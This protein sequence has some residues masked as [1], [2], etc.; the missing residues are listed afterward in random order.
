MNVLIACEESQ[1]VCIE[2]RKRGH[3]AYSCDIQDCSGC[4]PEWH[5]K[6]DCIP[7]LNGNC[8][9][10]TMDGVTHYTVGKW[11]L[12]IAHPPCTFL[13]KAGARWMYANGE[14]NTDRYA[15]MLNAKMF[16]Q[17]ISNADC[18]RI[19]I[20][21][22]VPLKLACLPK[23]SQI[24]QP[25]LFDEFGE[26]PF[27]KTTCLWFYGD[28]KPLIATTP[29]KLP[30]ACYCPS[31]TSLYSKGLA[32]GDVGIANSSKERSKTFRGIAAAMAEQWG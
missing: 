26:H 11:D 22:P 10:V 13:S 1:R 30:I 17:Q 18:D 2:F 23:P 24:I 25:Y 31:N 15:L 4:H 19:V 12:I 21:N 14:L 8:Q 28:V 5:I 7:L 29:D 3:N 6:G 20:E 16:F 9:F 27:K 32:K